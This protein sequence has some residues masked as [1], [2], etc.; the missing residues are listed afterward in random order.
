MAILTFRPHK[1]RILSQSEGYEDEDGNW[2]EGDSVWSEPI[3]CDAVPNG[4][5]NER[6]FEDGVKRGYSYTVH[7]PNYPKSMPDLEMG[8]IVRITLYNDKER[9][10]EIKGFHRYQLKAKAWV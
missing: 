2:H 10:F 7:L 4:S 9:E 8:D 5:G 3:A 1:L 6:T